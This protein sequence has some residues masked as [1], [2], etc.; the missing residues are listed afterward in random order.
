MS[1]NTVPTHTRVL[2]KVEGSDT[3]GVRRPG[4]FLPRRSWPIAVVASDG[5]VTRVTSDP[6]PSRSALAEMVKELQVEVQEA[7][8]SHV[9]DLDEV[10]ESLPRGSVVLVSSSLSCGGEA[11]FDFFTAWSKKM[12][13]DLSVVA[14]DEAVTTSPSWT[15]EVVS[16]RVAQSYV[17][18]LEVHPPRVVVVTDGYAGRIVPSSPEAWVW[19]VTRDHRDGLGCSWMEEGR[20]LMDH[21]DVDAFPPRSVREL[22]PG[23]AQDDAVAG[24]TSVVSAAIGLHRESRPEFEYDDKS[25]GILVSAVMMVTGGLFR[26]A[27]VS[28]E[29]HNQLVS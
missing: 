9:V 27:E 15:S 24:L 19:L 3:V 20:Y 11:W 29:V 28:R 2:Y 7:E 13:L 25:L 14:F 8:L 16:H 6:L 26:P 21:V 4:Q 22:V 12:D 18:N 10:L 1:T 17:E 5:S 23:P